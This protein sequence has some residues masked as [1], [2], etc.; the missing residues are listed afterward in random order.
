MNTAIAIVFAAALLAAGGD[1]EL[2]P[3]P[4][5]VT[6]YQVFLECEGVVVNSQK[7]PERAGAFFVVEIVKP[8]H[9]TGSKIYIDARTGAVKWEHSKKEECRRPINMRSA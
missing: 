1:Q 6:R 2:A 8:V 4:E 7:F 9:L 5:V 3:G